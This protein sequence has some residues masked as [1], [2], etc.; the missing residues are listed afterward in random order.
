[1]RPAPVATPA[2]RAHRVLVG[3]DRSP[4]AEVCL[5]YAITV[6]RALDSELTL[7]HVMRPRSGRV[8][9]HNDA[10]GWEISRQEAHLYLERLQAKAAAALGRPAAIRLEQGRP[11]ERIVELARELRSDLIVL[12]SHGEGGVTAW[13]LG[14]TAQHVL[15]VSHVSV[16]VAH[17]D[18]SVPRDPPD[19]HVVVAL[20][21]SQRAESA[22]PTAAR[23]AHT[24]GGDVILIHA[25]QESISTA[26]LRS[27]ED[28]ELARTLAS[29]LEINA[30]TYLEGLRTALVREGISVRTLVV[31]HA[32]PR[33]CI[34]EFASHERAGLV[35]V[36][37][38]GAV[39][40]S[41]R[42]FGS[43]TEYLL[44]HASIPVLVL[45]DLA[46][47]DLQASG[48]G[49]DRAPPLRASFPPEY[50]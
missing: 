25:V 19:R 3:V 7:V 40:D 30:K 36:A 4:L 47:H 27:V 39:C 44:T 49:V 1:M 37:A 50:A 11:S 31:R 18:G 35:V 24:S 45:Q 23:I 15:A 16:F 22:L 33:Q 9:P 29:R 17:A 38:H 6:A 48:P 46:E 12:A 13:N 10:L 26:V 32:N 42:T 5:P 41:T 8:A 14:S 20:D 2:A 34:L 28:L 43:V 21:G